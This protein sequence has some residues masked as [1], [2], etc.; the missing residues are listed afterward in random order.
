ML[1]SRAYKLEAY[2]TIHVLPMLPLCV[3]PSWK[4]LTIICGIVF[5]L[6]HLWALLLI[7]LGML[8][9]LRNFS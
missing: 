3:V 6:W 1:S 9:L 8:I 7:G 4:V 2:M 5:V